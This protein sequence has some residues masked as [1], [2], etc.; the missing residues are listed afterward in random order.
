[1]AMTEE[2]VKQRA[3]LYEMEDEL[4]R[5][6]KRRAWMFVLVAAAIGMGGIWAIVHFAVQQIADRPLKDLQKQLILAE[7]QADGAK[8]AATASRAS[9]DQRTTALSSPR[10]RRPY[11]QKGESRPREPG[12]RSVALASAFTW[13]AATPPAGSVSLPRT[14]NIS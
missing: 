5:L 14:P 2:E 1:M 10:R 3:V 13:Q 4:W 11:V 7:A 8:A 6:V 12:A 9:A